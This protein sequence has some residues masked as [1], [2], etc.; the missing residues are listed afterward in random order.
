MIK[1]IR[2]NIFLNYCIIKKRCKLINMLQIFKIFLRAYVM[3]GLCQ[4]N[5]GLD[6][7]II[8]NKEYIKILSILKKNPPQSKFSE[9]FNLSKGLNC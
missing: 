5:L 2:L 3:F 8:T 6:E 7:L 4:N 1:I 9:N